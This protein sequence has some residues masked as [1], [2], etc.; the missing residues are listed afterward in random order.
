MRLAITTIIGVLCS[1]ATAS[2]TGYFSSGQ[3]CGK[4]PFTTFTNPTTVTPQTSDEGLKGQSLPSQD[5][6]PEAVCGLSYSKT[7][8]NSGVTLGQIDL[9]FY[10]GDISR[11]FYCYP[12]VVNWDGIKTVGAN[13]YSCWT[14]GGCPS[15]DPSFYGNGT[16]RW[17]TPISG[18]TYYPIGYSVH[19]YY[20]ESPGLVNSHILRGT[21]YNVN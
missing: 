10:D 20:P 16:L 15:P 5:T 9:F 21:R 18:A 3:Q 19:C 17:T 2:A 13:R 1:A 4:I 12:S 11:A 7:P 14:D 8:P 6:L